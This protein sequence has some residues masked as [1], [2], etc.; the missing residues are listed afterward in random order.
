MSARTAVN[1]SSA[2]GC[3]GGAEQEPVHGRALV[4][5]ALAVGLERVSEKGVR[6]FRAHACGQGHRV[7]VW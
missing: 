1:T 2:V 7:A 4:R 6:L 5:K 3:V